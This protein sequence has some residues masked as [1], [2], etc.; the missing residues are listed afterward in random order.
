[1]SELDE[2]TA[3]NLKSVYPDLVKIFL[4]ARDLCA[5]SN[6][7]IPIITSSPRTAAEQKVLV[8]RGASTTQHSRHLPDNNGHVFAIDVAFVIAGKLRWDWPL[9]KNFAAIMKQA[10]D[11][12]DLPVEWGGDWKTFKDGPHFQLPWKSYP[13]N[14]R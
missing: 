1:M 2:R 5:L 10:A 4:K 7:P 3:T 12:L 6:S 13:A 14:K 8:A 11:E 9:Y